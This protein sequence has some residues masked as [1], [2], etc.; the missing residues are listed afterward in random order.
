MEVQLARVSA[1]PS[2]VNRASTRR[3]VK[4]FAMQPAQRL[5]SAVRARDSRT[6]LPV[7]CVTLPRAPAQLRL[8]RANSVLAVAVK[9]PSHVLMASVG[10]SLTSVMILVDE[11]TRLLT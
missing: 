9:L 6:V 4:A 1:S 3:A 2:W 10:R 7:S 11:L 5:P 8:E